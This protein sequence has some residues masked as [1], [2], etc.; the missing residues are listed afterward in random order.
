MR[1]NV[2]EVLEITNFPQ[3]KLKYK[4]LSNARCIKINATNKEV[5]T[6]KKIIVN[7]KKKIGGVVRGVIES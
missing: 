3:F 4:Y 7:A 5:P 1:K 6:I 2:K